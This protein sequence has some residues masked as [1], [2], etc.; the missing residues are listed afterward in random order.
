MHN[1]F[2]IHKEKLI[3]FSQELVNQQAARI[4][5]Y[6]Q[7]NSTGYWFGGGNML[8]LSEGI[9]IVGRYRN[10]GDSRTGVGLGDRGLELAIFRADCFDGRFEKVRCFSKEELS[11]SERKA[12]SIEGASLFKSGDEL[13]LYVSTE[14]DVSYPAELKSFQKSGAG[15][16]SIDV[17]S[18][19]DIISL[20]TAN[21]KTAICSQDHAALHVKD[22]VVFKIPLTGVVMLYGC[23]PF[24]WSSGNTGMAILKDGGFQI[25]T[26]EF[27]PR[28]SVWDVAEFRI[29]ERMPVPRLG[30]FKDLPPMSLYF[31]DGAEC[32]RKLE[33]HPNAWSR[34]RGYS[35]E[36]IAGIAWGFDDEFP[37]IERLSI[38]SPLFVSPN[39][40]GCCRYI[41]TLIT[42]DAIHCSW[43]QS[44]KDFS[45]PLV[46]HSLPM[47]KVEQIL[48]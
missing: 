9:F 7:K 20:S 33:E 1:I 41:S 19:K 8:K 4:L 34:P 36:E 35:C 28:G 25:V 43:Q 47:E 38:D 13:Q 21:I 40:T 30:C 24:T 27:Y 31:Y 6:P 5:V 18:G 2:K 44:Q 26:N 22:P 16:W 29:T 17:F 12:V 10:Y 42:D 15:V 37:K 23:N 45:Q 32:V 3:K 48:T 39:G 46:G 14:K 11:F